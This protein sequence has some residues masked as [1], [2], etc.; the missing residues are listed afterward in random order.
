M[1]SQWNIEVRDGRLQ[2]IV[3]PIEKRTAIHRY[4]L[5]P[6]RLHPEFLD[7]TPGFFDRRIDIAQVQTAR[8]DHS[9]VGFGTEIPDPIV[10]SPAIGR[11][12]RGFKMRRR[13][14]EQPDRRINHHIVD[15][16]PVHSLVIDV[17]WKAL[18]RRFFVFGVLCYRSGKAGHAAGG[19]HVACDTDFLGAGQ[20]IS[21]I[22]RV[23]GI[24]DRKAG[25]R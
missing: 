14:Q 10:I 23:K 3:T 19:Q 8:P 9:P 16:H 15:S 25:S 13:P 4:R 5:N 17:G 21:L 6:Q 2:W 20:R 22:F 12:G 18:T 1:N 24:S 7:A 11:P